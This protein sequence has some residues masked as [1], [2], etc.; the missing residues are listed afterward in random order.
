[1]SA[2]EHG[3]LFKGAMIRALLDGR[4]TVTRRVPTRHNSTVDGRRWPEKW[5][6]ELDWTR[7]VPDNVLDGV[8]RPCFKVPEKHP[9]PEQQSNREW[10]R[11]RPVW[12][13]G[14]LV[15]ARETWQ[16]GEPALPS[17]LGLVLGPPA[18]STKVVFRADWTGDDQPPWRSP[19]HLPRR[20]A[21]ILRTLGAVRGERLQE[22]TEEDAKAEGV[23]P[24]QM[25]MGSY[26]PSFEGLWDSINAP[27]G[28]GWEKNPPVWVL[29][30]DEVRP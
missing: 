1:L 20:F 3:L 24:L 23:K 5:W 14:D 10:H 8:P 12:Q 26:L 29:P 16:C 22:I 30:L 18:S 6:A 28:Y 9:A 7:A 17:G 21:R 25:D 11:V 19:L 13:P 4:K 27:R 2:K 15:W